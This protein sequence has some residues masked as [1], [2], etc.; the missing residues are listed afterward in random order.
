MTD[1]GQHNILEEKK[2]KGSRNQKRKTPVTY[3]VTAIIQ[4]ACFRS[5][6]SLLYVPSFIPLSFFLSHFPLL[7]F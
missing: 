4:S 5:V 3:R 2:K 1:I 7:Y 6:W